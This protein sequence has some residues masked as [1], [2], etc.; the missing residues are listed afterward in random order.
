MHALVIGGTGF[1]GS[2]AVRALVSRGAHVDVF[3]RGRTRVDLP[4]A[5]GYV[6][7]DRDDIASS[8]KML[9]AAT[10]DVVL[11]MTALTEAHA[12]TTIDVFCG[13]ARRLVAVT[14]MD[15]YR[16]FDV[17]NGRDDG[18]L[19]PVPLNED[20]ELR[21]YLFPARDLPEANRPIDRPSDYEK[22]LVERVYLNEPTLPAT[23]LR[24]PIVYGPGDVRRHR[25][26]PYVRRMTDGRP[27]ILLGQSFSRWTVTRGYVG[28]VAAAIAEAVLN[29]HAIG[30]TY[31]VGDALAL[32]ELAW[33]R[34]LAEAAAWRGKVVVVPDESV[35]AGLHFGGNAAQ[36]WVLDTSRIRDELHCEEPVG[37]KEALLQTVAWERT[38]PPQDRPAATLQY[39]AEDAALAHL[40]QPNGSK[41]KNDND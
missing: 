41:G 38:T 1:I 26:F 19:Q 32:T 2:H 25:T 9:R 7:G 36:D 17:I 23:I 24:L 8:S 15:V 10:P 39:D 37:L 28:N 35:P 16:A 4:A 30:R 29:D 18:P 22:I 33:V 40:T 20:A 3:H 12:R 27:A 13:V 14:S 11:D 31:N 21:R 5:V 34:T 6:H